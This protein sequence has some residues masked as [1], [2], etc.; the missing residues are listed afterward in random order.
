V[1]SLAGERLDGALD[2]LDRPAADVLARLS[3]ADPAARSAR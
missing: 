1:R 3:A 2:N